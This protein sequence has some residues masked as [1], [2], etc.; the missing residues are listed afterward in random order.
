VRRARKVK[1]SVRV[2]VAL[3]MVAMAAVTA[4]ATV[5]NPSLRAVSVR[6]AVPANRLRLVVPVA[7]PTTSKRLGSLLPARLM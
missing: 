6:K 5:A 4:P 1:A 7:L 3:P 2:P